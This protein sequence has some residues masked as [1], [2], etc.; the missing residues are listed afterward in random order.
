MLDDISV[1][2]SN[3]YQEFGCNRLHVRQAYVYN[4]ELE[5]SVGPTAELEFAKLLVIGKPEAGIT[6][7]VE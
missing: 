1:Q 7:I 3:C 5:P 2:L 6:S 4:I